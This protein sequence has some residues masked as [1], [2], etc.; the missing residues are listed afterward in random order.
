M[1]GIISELDL[2]IWGFDLPTGWALCQGYN[3][4]LEQPPRQGFDSSME[5]PLFR[6]FEYHAKGSRCSHHCSDSYQILLPRRMRV[7]A[8][9]SFREQLRRPWKWKI[10]SQRVRS[11]TNKI[12][13][14]RPRARRTRVRIL[15]CA[16]ALTATSLQR[17]LPDSIATENESLGARLFSRA[18]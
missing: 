6:V 5:Q 3:P 9:A 13:W 17:F 16:P 15:V 12:R 18:T 7:W 14:L 10:C 11:P 1:S 2:I 8:R 4:S